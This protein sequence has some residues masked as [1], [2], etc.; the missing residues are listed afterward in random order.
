LAR[1]GPTWH[2][3]CEIALDVLVNTLEQ[4]S[5]EYVVIEPATSGENPDWPFRAVVG[6]SL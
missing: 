1:C 6:L 2:Q 4:F 3:R 5:R